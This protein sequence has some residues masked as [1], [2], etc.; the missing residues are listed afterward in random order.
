[1]KPFSVGAL[2]GLLF[3]SAFDQV[4]S[5]ADWD[6]KASYDISNTCAATSLGSLY[7]RPSSGTCNEATTCTSNAKTFCSSDSTTAATIADKFGAI[8]YL[9]V[10]KYSGSSCQTLTS[11]TAYALTNP[12]DCHPVTISTGTKGFKATTINPLGPTSVTD[13]VA[14]NFFTDSTCQTSD[15]SGDF[16]VTK[17]ALTSG[18]PVGCDNTGT[19]K[20]EISAT[21]PVTVQ[22]VPAFDGTLCT[23]DVALV[24]STIR[25]TCISDTQ[26][27]SST[28]GKICTSNTD[29]KADFATLFGKTPHVMVSKFSGSACTSTTM[30]SLMAYAADGKCHMITSSSKYY[31]GVISAGKTKTTITFYSNSDC[32]TPLLTAGNE[33]IVVGTTETDSNV[34]SV[35]GCDGLTQATRYET[36]DSWPHSLQVLTQF[37]GGDCS[38][39]LGYISADATS[40]SN[41]CTADTDCASTTGAGAICTTDYQYESAIAAKFGSTPYVTIAK[42]TTSC[43]WATISTV[44]AYAA[45]GQCHMIAA[46]KYYKV[47]AIPFGGGPTIAKITGYN[48]PTC[49]STSADSS[50][51]GSAEISVTKNQINGGCDITTTGGPYTYKISANWPTAMTV[52]GTGTYA[53][54]STGACTGT[55]SKLTLTTVTSTDCTLSKATCTAVNI[56]ADC[57]TIPNYKTYLS[58]AFGAAPYLIKES[59]SGSNCLGAISSVTGYVADGTCYKEGSNSVKLVATSTGVFFRTWASDGDCGVSVTTTVPTDTQVP[60]SSLVSNACTSNAKYYMKGSSWT[61]ASNAVYDDS[62]CALTPNKITFGWAPTCATPTGDA[63]CLT[64]TSS[65][66]TPLT[67]YNA[68]G[69]SKAS[70]ANYF[71]AIDKAFGM[72][73]YVVQESYTACGGSLTGVTAY[74]ADSKCHLGADAS[75]S[76]NVTYDVNSTTAQVKIQTY[77]STDCTTGAATPVP[78]PAATITG[79]TCADNTKTY[80]GGLATQLTAVTTYSDKLCTLPVQTVFSSPASTCTPVTACTAS[81]AVF[82]KTACTNAKTD[83]NAILT[84]VYSTTRRLVSD[85]YEAKDKEKCGTRQGIVAYVADGACHT[86][87]DGTFFKV[88][89]GSSNTLTDATFSTF[90]DKDCTKDEKPLTIAA[91]NLAT[92]TTAPCDGTNS[93]KWSIGGTEPPTE[94]PATDAPTPAPTTAVSTGSGKSAAVSSFSVSIFG[95]LASV[96]GALAVLLN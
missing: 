32:S 55:P 34:G 86:T 44:S 31:Q 23:S 62:K 61:F 24:S 65:A 77:T 66:T 63:A 47:T 54:P 46:N 85:I 71:S 53:I 38:K 16:T 83:Y 73:T 52:A 91:A 8:P 50:V 4:S 70:S 64:T 33:P 69:C 96:L 74:V 22:A 51:L 89:P 27:S 95:L 10:S 82:T 29:Y 17:A 84:T 57:S 78:I 7:L 48:D 2:A 37:D 49:V 36:S 60:T 87:L 20:Y 43:S 94:A 9:K 58:T 80:V 19:T 59:Y 56:L 68:P 21:Y 81:G 15:S 79:K 11:V 14:I 28:A 1:M 5:A 76:Y 26:C 40:G 25:G 42:Y 88:T 67:V 18:T 45:D 75:S 3:A 72:T 13:A 39:T 90:S 35:K 41:T 6:A 30:T 92:A 93:I 12:T